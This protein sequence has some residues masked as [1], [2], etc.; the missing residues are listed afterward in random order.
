MGSQEEK[1][2]RERDG[3]H[4]ALVYE[5]SPVPTLH[6]SL[7]RFSNDYGPHPGSTVAEPTRGEVQRGRPE[8]LTPRTPPP[9]FRLDRRP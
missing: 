4:E 7:P 5:F 6:E 1:K 9:F 8:F 3:S 2:R